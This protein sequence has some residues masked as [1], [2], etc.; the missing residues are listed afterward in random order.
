MSCL[1]YSDTVST[2]VAFSTNFGTNFRRYQPI[3][4]GKSVGLCSKFRSCT[5]ITLGILLRKELYPSGEKKRV[6]LYC[7]NIRGI[8]HSNQIQYNK[9]CLV[10]GPITTFFTLGNSGSTTAGSRSKIS[11]NL[12]SLYSVIQRFTSS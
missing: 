2:R 5:V 10:G 9:G 7:F 3:T 11:T 12:T 1:E 6:A 8:D 4:F